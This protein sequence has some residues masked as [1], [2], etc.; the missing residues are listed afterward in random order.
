MQKLKQIQAH[1]KRSVAIVGN[2]MI[3]LGIKVSLSKCKCQSLKLIEQFLFILLLDCK[4]NS[5]QIIIYTLCLTS[6]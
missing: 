2:N 6:S 5:N 3:Q 4:T 1:T